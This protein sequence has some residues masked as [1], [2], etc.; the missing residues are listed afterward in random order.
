[1]PH[2][3]RTPVQT[4][5]ALPIDVFAE[6]FDLDLR[7]RGRAEATRNSYGRSISLFVRW[8]KETDRPLTLDVSP[9][10]VRGFIVYQK[11]HNS[12]G[13][14]SA[15]FKAL[16]QLFSFAVREG[17]IEVS[18]MATLRAPEV[19]QSSPAIV[20][21]DVLKKLVRTRTGKSMNE[22]RD[23]ALLRTFA[24]TG[25]RLSEVT[26]LRHGDIDKMRQ[27]VTITGKGNKVRTVTIGAKALKAIDSYS[28]AVRKAHPELA[29]DDGRLRPDAPL[30]ISRTGRAMTVSGID[31]VLRKMCDDAQIPR[32]H[33]HL[34]R[35]TFADAWFR[36]GASPE[37]LMTHAGWSSR[38]MLEV[39]ARSTREER[40]QITAKNL[41][42]GDRF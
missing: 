38:S 25:C 34:F 37:D 1:M 42:L 10:D 17:E 14:A 19:T 16:Q 27:T 24:D 15:R 39:Y 9:D 5:P 11:T 33:W 2:N 21:D 8:L 6:S 32:L 35:H 23:V 4:A 31:N 7:Q 20:S 22:L 13:T 30:W 3:R 12:T 29:G 18:P 40:A 26:N 41:A 36:S 28:R